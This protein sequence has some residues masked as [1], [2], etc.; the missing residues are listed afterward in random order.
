MAR[1]GSKRSGTLGYAGVP[2]LGI[3]FYCA[4]EQILTHPG[5]PKGSLVRLLCSGRYETMAAIRGPE[6]PCYWTAD[7]GASGPRDVLSP[8]IA[9]AKADPCCGAEHVA[10]AD[11]RR[12]P[13]EDAF[14]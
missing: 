14:R 8:C 4:E 12:R 2:N 9:M 1:R 11:T 6:I 5:V 3:E 13:R 10:L 7:L